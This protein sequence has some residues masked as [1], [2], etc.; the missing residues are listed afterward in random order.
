MPASASEHPAT[1]ELDLPAFHP[2][3]RAAAWGW[4]EHRRH[5]ARRADLAEPPELSATLDASPDA[6]A[7][8]DALAPSTRERLLWTLVSAAR[9]ETKAK[10]VDRIVTDA[11]ARRRP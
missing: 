11:T 9:A 5:R 2:A 1:W 8:R 4:L 7:A 3:D 6:R 10:R